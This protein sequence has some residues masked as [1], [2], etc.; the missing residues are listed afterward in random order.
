MHGKMVQKHSSCW[1]GRTGT[2]MPFGGDLSRN[3]DF[4]NLPIRI[5]V[6]FSNLL[7]C[8]SASQRAS[9]SASL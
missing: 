1:D 5:S 2:K 9:R 7:T 3:I 4:E 8:I 6:K